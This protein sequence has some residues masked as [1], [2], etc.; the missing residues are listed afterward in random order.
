M[1][2]GDEW[3]KRWITGGAHPMKVVAATLGVALSL[4]TAPM[5]H[6]DADMLALETQS[7]LW[8]EVTSVLRQ[9]PTATPSGRNS[10]FCQ[11]SFD[12]REDVNQ[13]GTFG[14]GALRW[15]GANMS[16]ANPRLKLEY[17]QTYTWGDWTIYSD[18]SGTRFTDTGTGHGMFVSRENVYGF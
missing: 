17:G 2:E 14:D 7:G 6:A 5:A 18:A 9:Y 8:C 11:G 1:D 10:A 3:M 12:Q 4:G 13:V 15:Q 16:S